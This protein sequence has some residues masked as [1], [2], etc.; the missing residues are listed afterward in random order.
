MVAA[1]SRANQNGSD[2]ERIGARV[3]E[4]RL[5]AGKRRF[6]ATLVD[7]IRGA[8]GHCRGGTDHGQ[9]VPLGPGLRFRGDSFRVEAR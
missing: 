3:D 2:I 5:R 8:V 7:V 9:S 4:D 1:G 6:A